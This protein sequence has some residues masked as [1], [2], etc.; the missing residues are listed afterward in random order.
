M[1]KIK[2]GIIGCGSISEVYLENCTNRFDMLEMA[3]CADA[4]PERAAA[5]AEQ[6]P[7]V[8][9]VS[10]E[11][12]LGDPS[13]DLVLNLT[14]PKA[15]H[16]VCKAALLAGKHVYVEKPLSIEREDARELL[17]LAASGHLLVG[18]APDTFL[19]G[20]LQTCRKLLDDGW[21]GQPIAATAFMMSGGPEDW[22]PDPAFLYQYGAGPLFDM[23]PYYLTALISLLGPAE[24]VFALQKKTFAQRT[25]TSSPKYGQKI[26]V[27]VP[28]YVSGLLQFE[29]GVAA[30]LITSFDVGASTL[31]FLE[32]YG[33]EGTLCAGDPNTFGGPVRIRRKGADDWSEIPLAYGNAD[34]ARGLGLADM[35]CAIL[36]GRKHRAAGE[37]AFH[38][39]DILHGFGESA[40]SGR[41]HRLESTCARPAAFPAGTDARRLDLETVL[42][43]A[44]A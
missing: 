38:V 43:A 32:L 21:I 42:Q 6:F 3:A 39:L 15:H 2:V 19:G 16:D 9:A 40:A 36:T 14:I 20:G 41:L 26:D 11:K 17:S 8:R 34:N 28:T 12:L 4:V 23:G 7:G 25:I 1:K 33:S 44:G 27:E 37:L 29:N 22:H 5:R 18:G 30:N 13:I 10:V 31:P 24:S 35:A